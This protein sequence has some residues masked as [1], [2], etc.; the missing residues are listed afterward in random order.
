MVT[1]VVTIV[2]KVI[3][4]AAQMDF[5]LAIIMVV[6]LQYSIGHVVPLALHFGVSHLFVFV[7]SFSFYSRIANYFDDRKYP[8]VL[9]GHVTFHFAS[10]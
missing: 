6:A 1:N 4:R 5:S 8:R 3:A 7:V 10:I 9:A 2:R